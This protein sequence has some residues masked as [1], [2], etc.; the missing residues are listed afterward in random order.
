[1]EIKG[2]RSVRISFCRQIV[3]VGWKDVEIN[4]F[5]FVTLSSLKNKFTVR[6]LP[7]IMWCRRVFRRM[8][9]TE[10]RVRNQYKSPLN[11]CSPFNSPPPPNI[12]LGG[13]SCPQRSIVIL[14]G[15]RYI[16]QSYQYFQNSCIFPSTSV[17]LTKSTFIHKNNDKTPIFQFFSETISK[18]KIN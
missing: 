17:I 6:N 12:F 7:P 18:Y 14:E 15:V 13:L 11:G 3:C 8:H 9:T 2:K 10:I 5:L 16:K 1:M 4:C